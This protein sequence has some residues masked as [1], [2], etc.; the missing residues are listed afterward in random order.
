MSSSQSNHKGLLRKASNRRK[1][2]GRSNQTQ[3]NYPKNTN[4]GKDAS[5]DK[6]KSGGKDVHRGGYT[7]S[8]QEGKSHRSRTRRRK[9][10][11]EVTQTHEESKTPDNEVKHQTP[12]K[13]RRRR[14]NRRRKVSPVNSNIM[15]LES[16]SSVSHVPSPHVNQRGNQKAYTISSNSSHGS[17]MEYYNLP[18]AN[19]DVPMHLPVFE[20]EVTGQKVDFERQAREN[21]L[22][23]LAN[24]EKE[25]NINIKN[26]RNIKNTRK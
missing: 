16:S 11:K 19:L 5:N 14:R 25:R 17:P 24:L 6:N 20:F 18:W 15:S 26:I 10:Q 23:W 12:R 3:K 2:A 1:R 8:S 21:H 9:K 13:Q 7:K 22:R 4:P